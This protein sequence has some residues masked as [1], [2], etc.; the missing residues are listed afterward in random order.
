M[1]ANIVWLLVGLVMLGIGGEAL[2]R[3]AS[4]LARR[5]GISALLVGLTVVAFGTS[6]PEVAVSVLAEI[7]H[8]DAI[9]VSNVVGSC[10]LNSL[11]VLG[12]AALARPLTVSRA[13]LDTDAPFMILTL[14]VFQLLAIDGERIVRWEGLALV[15]GLV[16]YILLTYRN[17]RAHD[18]AVEKDYSAELPANLSLTACLGLIAIGLVGLVKGADFI[19]FSAEQIATSLGVSQ[20]IIGLT[21]VALGTSLP[22]IVTCVVAARRGHPDIA[23]GNVVGSNIFNILCVVGVATG[24]TPRGELLFDKQTLFFDIPV[25]MAAGVIILPILRTGHCITRREGGFLLALYGV[26]MALTFGR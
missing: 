3:G 21:I 23:I 24:F 25:M 6:A 22:E 14:A 4:A 26:Y 20:R 11:L 5:L 19:V 16:G 1:I 18:R 12:L 10:T 17:T 9:A 2:V 7:R 15:V 8:Q 13:V